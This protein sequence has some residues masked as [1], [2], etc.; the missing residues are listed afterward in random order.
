MPEMATE[1]E[2]PRTDPLEENEDE[3]GPVKPFL[4]HLEDLR[5]VLIKSLSAVGITILVCLL[6]G[7]V[8][9]AFL[10]RPLN[11]T[12]VKYPSAVQVASFWLGTNQLGNFQI[13]ANS[14]GKFLFGTNR[15]VA[16]HLEPVTVGET[17]VLGLRPDEK[18]AENIAQKL[19]CTYRKLRSCQCF[20]PRVSSRNLRWHSD[21]LAFSPL[22]YRLFRLSRP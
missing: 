18:L 9:V 3:G 13:A 15:Y 4:D 2:E 17:I 11:H 10:L 7:N 20:Y 22:F 19:K 8:V 16:F 21:R 6:A 1:A 5:W 14:P 12:Y